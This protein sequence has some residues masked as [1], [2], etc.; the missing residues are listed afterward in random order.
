M[1]KQYDSKEWQ[2]VPL[3]ETG[4]W[5][6]DL[7]GR[8]SVVKL[9]AVSDVELRLDG[10]NMEGEIIA[11]E[12]GKVLRIHGQFVDF[13]AIQISSSEGFT[14]RATVSDGLELVDPTPVVLTESRSPDPVRLAMADEIKKQ[15]NQWKLEGMFTDP[16]QAEKEY[17]E[18][19]DDL[20][21]GDMEFPDGMDEFG[22][23]A[24][25]EM[26][27]ERVNQARIEAAADAQDEK[28]MARE[29]RSPAPPAEQPLTPAVPASPAPVPAS[30]AT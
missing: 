26:E 10:I 6:F 4:A 22:L 24:A 9:E 27:E 23:P 14:V 13:R 12:R 21:D 28:D 16:A 15:L 5:V 2:Y 17:E 8:P 3:S 30:S 25:A 7:Y 20:V 1:I 18:F 19:I 29:R 11:L